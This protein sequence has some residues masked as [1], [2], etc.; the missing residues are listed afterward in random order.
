[1]FY[2]HRDNLM[3]THKS[4]KLCGVKQGYA[5]SQKVMPHDDNL[6]MLT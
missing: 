6:S 3:R 4:Y 5:R 2:T 1:M